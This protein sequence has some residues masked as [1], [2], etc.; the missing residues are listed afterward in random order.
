[1]MRTFFA[2][3]SLVC[4]V[5]AHAQIAAVTNLSSGR[6][7]PGVAP[8]SFVTVYGTFASVTATAASSVP[9]PTTLGGVTVTV[10]GTAVPLH[11]VGPTQIN[12]IVPPAATTGVKNLVVTTGTGPLTSTIR[13]VNTAPGLNVQDT[14]TPPKGAILNQNNSLNAQNAPARGGEVIQIFG[15]GPGLFSQDVAAGTATPASPLITTR[16]T[17]QVYIGAVP[18]AVQ[19][20]GLTPGSVGLWQVNAVVPAVAFVTGRVPVQIFVD[21]V[22]SNEVTAFVAQ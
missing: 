2:I 19:F 15:T 8:G 3:A 9:F 22:D 4:C 20:S 17:P 16:S 18:A 10:D 1:M 6:V 5:S 14:A 7:L 11:F 13:I 21:G 12:L